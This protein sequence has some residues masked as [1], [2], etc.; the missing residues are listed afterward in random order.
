MTPRSRPEHPGG[1][2]APGSVRG[3][4]PPL[5]PEQRES[6]AEARRRAEERV[7]REAGFRPLP[8]DRWQD[9][10]G[11]GHEHSRGEA[12]ELARRD[13]ARGEGEP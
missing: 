11:E 1:Y 7:L 6:Y 3:E 12:L 5:S 9:A 2:Y 4:P 13:L 10:G 8:G